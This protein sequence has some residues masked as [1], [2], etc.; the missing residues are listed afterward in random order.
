MFVPGTNA[1]EAFGIAGIGVYG[2]RFFRK[3][4]RLHV[5]FKHRARPYQKNVTRVRLPVDV[6][7]PRKVDEVIRKWLYEKKPKQ[8]AAASFVSTLFHRQIDAT[9]QQVSYME[10]Q[11]KRKRPTKIAGLVKASTSS[12]EAEAS[13]TIQKLKRCRYNMQKQQQRQ[14][15]KSVLQQKVRLLLLIA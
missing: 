2:K 1:G 3:D 5:E 9:V 13:P 6:Q 8:L 15:Q 12:A 4:E 14:L 10:F 11:N 7:L